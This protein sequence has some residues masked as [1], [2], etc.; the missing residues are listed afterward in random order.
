M[1]IILSPAKKMN[2]DTDSLLPLSVPVFL[3]STKEIA[4]WLKGKS[5]PELKKLWCC[6]DKIAGLNF[7]RLEKLDLTR[8]LTPSVLAY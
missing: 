6:N 7:R 3:E 1:K 4:A 8:N 5:Y 2:V